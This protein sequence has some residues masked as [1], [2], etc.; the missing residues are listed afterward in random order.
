MRTRGW[1][2]KRLRNT[3]QIDDDSLDTI[4]F[5]FDLRLKTLHLI[6]IERVGDILLCKSANGALVVEGKDCLP[7]EC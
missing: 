3:A 4:A 6:T 1:S 2:R 7:D 5:A